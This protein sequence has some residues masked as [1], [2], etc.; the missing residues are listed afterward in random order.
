[1]NDFVYFLLGFIVLMAIYFGICYKFFKQLFYHFNDVDMHL[2]NPDDEFYADAYRWYGEIP[3]EDVHIKSYDDLKLHGVFL[4]SHDKKTN[5][6]AIVIHG[7]QSKGYDMVIIAKMYSDLGFQV[8]LIDQRGHGESEGK[9]TSVGFYESMDLKKWLHFSTRTYGSDIQILLHGVSMGASTAVLATQ[10]PEIKHVKMMVLDSVFT[11]FRS[12]VNLQAKKLYL[13]LFIP[14]LSFISYLLLKFF[15]S[16]VNP[17]KHIKK[18]DIPTIFIHSGNDR[19]VSIEMVETLHKHLKTDQK[20]ILSIDGAR[21]AKGFEV[22][23]DAY[24]SAVIQMTSEIFK[25]K[26]SDIKY[27]K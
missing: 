17:L 15:L 8:L 25:I 6:L 11:N 4:P 3:K 26:R 14:G 22:D 24:I 7:Y 12:S 16:Q 10:Y 2:V 23:K 13:K 20:S 5:K 21:H 27:T 18:C 1:M 19:V 9:F